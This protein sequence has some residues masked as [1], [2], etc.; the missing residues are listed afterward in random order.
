M[1]TSFKSKL[2][3][4]ALLFAASFPALA[5]EA[6][7]SID[8]A[9]K[10]QEEVVL[11]PMEQDIVAL[12]KEWAHIKYQLSDKKRQLNALHT[13][14]VKAS[15]ITAKYPNNAEPKIWEGI[16]V[17]TDAGI[18]GGLSAL[19]KVKTAKKLFE[20]ALKMNPRAL[21]G[22][23]YTSL[24]SLYYQVPGWPIGFGDDDTAEEYLK[25]ALTI[26]P[27][28]IDPNFFYADFL[29]QDGRKAEAKIYFEKALK[30]PNR[31]SRPLADSGRR[32]E[33]KAALA[34]LS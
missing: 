8:K 27:D 17:S 11:T 10:I 9:Q 1:K 32:Q 28:G 14:E 33:I 4:S 23:A 12:Q 19:G 7:T 21:D 6:V 31:S 3:L 2:L 18:T 20:G 34:K 15:Q 24:G 29:V 13:L 16:I 22:S 25:K 26:N 30:A 5:Q